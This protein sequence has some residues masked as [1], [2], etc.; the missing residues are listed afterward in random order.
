MV[1]SAAPA[2]LLAASTWGLGMGAVALL[3]WSLFWDRAGGRRRCPRCWYD[4]A[5]NAGFTCPEC[6]HDASGERRLGRTRR[7]WRWVGVAAAL[8]LG[9]YATSS[10]PRAIAHG[11]PGL[12]PTWALAAWWPIDEPTWWHGVRTP[13]APALSDP[14]AAEFARRWRQREISRSDACSWIKRLRG[15]APAGAA[16]ALVLHTHDVK[17]LADAMVRDSGVAAYDSGAATCHLSDLCTSCT[18]D[19]RWF[20]NG[21]ASAYCVVAPGLLLVLAPRDTLERRPVVPVRDLAR[22]DARLRGSAAPDEG[23]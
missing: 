3:V 21:G 8:A 17:D 1:L 23:K 19:F 7:R 13:R 15:R 11:W 6:G 14:I 12:V 20:V 16:P 2:W 18:D 5:G 9:S 10:G 4:M 22:R